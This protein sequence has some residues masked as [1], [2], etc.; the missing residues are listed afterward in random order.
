MVMRGQKRKRERKKERERENECNRVGELIQTH[1]C[2]AG[3]IQGL[4]ATAAT[5]VCRSQRW[6]A[7]EGDSK[8]DRECQLLQSSVM[9]GW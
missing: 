4:M 2:Q 5:V 8:F 3:K 9:F 6:R 1:T 7:V